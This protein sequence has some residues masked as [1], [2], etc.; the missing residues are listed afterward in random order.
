MLKN[1]I[2]NIL[3]LLPGGL[4]IGVFDLGLL[5][6]ELVRG[7]AGIAAP[8]C[9]ST[10]AVSVEI[11]WSS[12][13]ILVAFGFSKQIY[14]GFHPT[15]ES[16]SY[17]HQVIKCIFTASS[18]LCLATWKA[19]IQKMSPKVNNFEHNR[20]F[21]GNDK[22]KFKDNSVYKFKNIFYTYIIRAHSCYFKNDFVFSDCPHFFCSQCASTEKFHLKIMC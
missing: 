6:E 4:G 22:G 11:L 19:R 13:E 1:H 5:A 8:I 18:V 3:I 21:K 10:I 12:W 17:M 2:R 16:L 7:C 9:V 15:S 14:F 20:T